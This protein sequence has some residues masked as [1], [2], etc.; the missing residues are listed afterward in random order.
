MI[1]I[2]I[3]L[4]HC[5]LCLPSAT[6]TVA[7]FTPPSSLVRHV[8]SAPPPAT[9]QRARQRARTQCDW[10]PRHGLGGRLPPLR[11]RYAS[12]SAMEALHRASPSLATLSSR[13]VCTAT[14]CNTPRSEGRSTA[15]KHSRKQKVKPRATSSSHECSGASAQESANSLDRPRSDRVQRGCSRIH[16]DLVDCFFRW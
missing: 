10:K 7:C 3:S 14:H 12:R 13:A 15:Y 16:V 11:A 1:C 9:Q 4:K 5:L 2:K 8:L 6:T